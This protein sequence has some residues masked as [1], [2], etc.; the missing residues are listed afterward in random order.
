MCL[1]YYPENS[2]CLGLER[3]ISWRPS[4]AAPIRTAQTQQEPTKRKLKQSRCSSCDGTPYADVCLPVRLDSLEEHIDSLVKSETT[5]RLAHD[6]HTCRLLEFV[7]DALADR[8]FSELGEIRRAQTGIEAATE[9]L[10]TSYESHMIGMSQ[11]LS[12]RDTCGR[13][14]A[15]SREENALLS[16]MLD[17]LYN[18]GIDLKECLAHAQSR[19]AEAQ[20]KLAEALQLVP[21]E[22]PHVIGQLRASQ[23]EVAKLKDDIVAKDADLARLQGRLREQEQKELEAARNFADKLAEVL[24][25]Q[26]EASRQA[27]ERAVDQA[28]QKAAVDL[29][30]ERGELKN[31]LQQEEL[32]R[33]D[34]ESKLSEAE[35]RIFAADEDN[36]QRSVQVSS[37]RE[38]LASA[39]VEAEKFEEREQELRA[40]LEDLK[41]REQETLTEIEGLK[42]Q[43]QKA[44][45]ELEAIKGREHGARAELDGFKVREQEAHVEL[46]AL[47]GREYEA[48]AELDGFKVREQEARA[49]LEKLQGDNATTLSECTRLRDERQTRAKSVSAV[50]DRIRQCAQKFSHLNEVASELRKLEEVHHPE[51][52]EEG[53]VVAQVVQM[54]RVFQALHGFHQDQTRQLAAIREKSVQHSSQGSAVLLGEGAKPGSSPAQGTPPLHST[55]QNTGGDTETGSEPSRTFIKLSHPIDRERRVTLQTP[56]ESPGQLIPPS[57]EQEKGNRR[58]ALLPQSIIKTQTTARSKNSRATGSGASFQRGL[59]NRMVSGSVSPLLAGKSGDESSGRR[60]SSDTT[61]RIKWEEPLEPTSLDLKDLSRSGEQPRKRTSSRSGVEDL[62]AATVTGHEAKRTKLG[63]HRPTRIYG[64]RRTELVVGSEEK[65]RQEEENGQEEKDQEES[66]G[67]LP[68]GQ[69]HVFRFS[70]FPQEI[71][72]EKPGI[73]GQ[74]RKSVAI[75]ARGLSSSAE[76]TTYST[77]NMRDVSL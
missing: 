12:E 24:Q 8:I 57:V 53:D 61:P 66:F 34:L 51:S 65:K 39:R 41:G 20:S 19:L 36:I 59:Y 30:K 15:E 17:E 29:D 64:S 32:Q 6:I 76:Q 46:E 73:F 16:T 70:S 40:E 22:D 71:L 25:R 35:G 1:S 49:E 37:L 2:G 26:E 18:E 38:E 14:L 5:A 68:Y 23:E 75:L 48:R 54:E 47:K 63:P 3:K 13:E 45:A 72:V 50:V 56:L 69:S 77:Q 11:R 27:T 10:G 74:L 31:I 44:R 33:R 55:T 62:E 42:E 21:S 52:P 43:E 9:R 58:G 60:Q 4:T 67:G 28:R 7:P